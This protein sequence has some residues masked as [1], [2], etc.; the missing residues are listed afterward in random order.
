[1]GQPAERLRDNDDKE[2]NWKQETE[3]H[4]EPAD[5]L[6][7]IDTRSTIHPS[8]GHGRTSRQIRHYI[9]NQKVTDLQTQT[10]FQHKTKAKTTKGKGPTHEVRDQQADGQGRRHH[11]RP[12]QTSVPTTE[13]RTGTHKAQNQTNRHRIPHN[14]NRHVN[15]TQ[16]RKKEHGRTQTRN[17]NTT[18]GT[19]HT[20]TG[21]QGQKRR[22][23]EHGQ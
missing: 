11:E 17:K 14:N 3:G 21:Q 13:D 20:Q 18:T 5:H 22:Q 12:Q 15:Y 23:Q 2:N 16:H 6:L 7:R 19:V 1:M 4:R 8:T 9:Y 10:R